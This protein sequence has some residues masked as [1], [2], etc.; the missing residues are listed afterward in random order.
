MVLSGELASVKLHTDDLGS[1]NLIANE[2]FKKR[3]SLLPQPRPQ[4]PG[5]SGS[6][7]TEVMFV[8]GKGT[9]AKI[10]R[11]ISDLSWTR[12]IALVLK[13]GASVWRAGKLPIGTLDAFARFL[14]VI[15]A[16][17]YCSVIAMVEN[18]DIKAFI[19][20]PAHER[21]RLNGIRGKYQEEILGPQIFRQLG[22]DVGEINDL[23]LSMAL[24]REIAGVASYAQAGSFDAMLSHIV[25]QS[26]VSLRIYTMVTGL[27]KETTDRGDPAWGVKHSMTGSTETAYDVFD[28]IIL[29]CPWN[30]SS[31]LDNQT[32]EQQVYYRSVHAT[33]LVTKNKLSSDYFGNPEAGE[34]VIIIQSPSLP[35]E[36]QG[37]REISYMRDFYS[38][39]ADAARHLY[40][41]L[42]PDPLP[43]ST[44]ALFEDADIVEILEE[45]IQDAYPL[46][47]PRSHDELGGTFKI[48]EG[49]WHSGMAEAVASSVDW[50]WVVGENLARLVARE[51]LEKRRNRVDKSVSRL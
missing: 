23:A 4:I 38:P 8:D 1:G 42:S 31:L 6:A 14:G 41:I 25:D 40:R 48:A 18:T 7:S 51:L 17:T 10:T 3:A 20:M 24:A 43:K 5:F 37:V 44:M 45:E 21:L 19:G 47:F 28:R 34:Q 33:F 36:L 39:E 9:M 49:I 11:P 22:Q 12:W 15:A 32:D 27:E 29:A 35:M 46:L 26:N 30:T 13:Y 16:G 2:I 50:S